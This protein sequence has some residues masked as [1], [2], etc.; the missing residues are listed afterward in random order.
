VFDG[1]TRY[2]LQLAF[3]RHDKVK[4]DTGYQGSVV[5]CAVKF[6]PVADFNPKRFLIT[7]L[8]AQHDIEIWLAPFA[9]SWLMVP[10]RVSIPTRMRL[11][12]LQATKFESIPARS[13]TTSL[14]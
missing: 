12:I 1:H 11:G 7:Y 4:T 2:N 14:N 3:K 6:I 13:P 8:A 5:V 10:Y 9:G